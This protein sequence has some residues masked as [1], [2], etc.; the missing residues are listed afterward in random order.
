M[1]IIATAFANRI[2][3]YSSKAEMFTILNYIM[4]IF[5][6]STLGLDKRK[7]MNL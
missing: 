7:E 6:S 3:L 1:P 4:I 5:A 2:Y